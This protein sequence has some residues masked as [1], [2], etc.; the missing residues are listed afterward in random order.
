MN[1]KKITEIKNIGK[2][3]LILLGLAGILLIGASYFESIKKKD[4]VEIETVKT[5]ENNNYQTQ[6]E[7]KIEKLI[8]SIE[9]VSKVSVMI[10]YKSGGEKV[11]QEDS[12]NSSSNR[13]D[14]NV[15]E[16]NSSVKKS[17]VL[18]QQDGNEEPYVIK[19]LYPEV[20]GIAVAAKGLSD[21]TK[22]E[23]VI[24]MLAAL[25]DIGVHKISIINI[26]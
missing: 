16:Q 4:E 3:K 25:F 7:E 12:E 22:K 14:G 9:G 6:T 1:I 23:E 18:F 26:N 17:T 19:E 20:S 21:S 13:Q 15:S 5:V 8:R 2:E 11:L 10:S 24:N